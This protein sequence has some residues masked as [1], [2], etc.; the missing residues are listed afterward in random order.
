MLIGFGAAAVNP[1]LAFE[2]IEDLIREGELTGIEPAAAVRNYLKALG[3]GVMKVMSKMGISTVAL[4][5]RRTGLR[6]RRHRQGRHRRVLHRHA[7]PTRRRRAR[8]HRRGGQAAAPP[9]LPGEPH[10]AGAPPPRGRRRVR[11]PPRGRTAPVHP[12]S[13]FPAAAFDPHRPP[14]HLRAVLRRG[15]PAVQGGRHAAR[16]V[17][18][19]EGPAATRA[20]GGGRIRRVHRHPVQHRRDELRLHLR[21]GPRDD[22]HRDEQPRRA[23]QLRR[24]RRRRRPALRPAS[25]AARSSRSRR[26]RFGVTSDYLVNATDIQIKMAQGAKPGEGGQ[27]PGYKVYPNI[28]KTR[29]STPGVGLISPPPHHDIYSIED[30]AQLIHDLKN[31][32]SDARIHVKLVSSRRRRHRRRGRVQGARRCRADL[33]LRRR[34]RRRTADQPQTRR[35]AVGDRSRR[36]PADPWC[37][38]ACATASPCSATAAC[39]PRAT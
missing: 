5:H 32:N 15:E 34:H 31:A 27:L 23:L 16:A 28:A 36:H 7:N 14:R 22:G 29:H 12:R 10:R 2:S 6:G 24:G 17:R 3:K 33:R 9:R 13:G 37:S 35:R 8:R 18:V 38:T 1:Y 20:A 39:A 19:Q 25:G 30:L 21:R 4:L 11:V 26:G